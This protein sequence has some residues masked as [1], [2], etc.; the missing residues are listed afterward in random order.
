MPGYSGEARALSSAF[1]G[2]GVS[3]VDW[4]GQA[5]KWVM[6]GKVPP[7]A[8]LDGHCPEGR[9]GA[10]LAAPLTLVPTP[11]SQKQELGGVRGRAVGWEV[12]IQQVER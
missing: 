9:V 7:Q 1:V 6:M 12:L 5:R 11:F 4:P 10:G 3:Q 8:R 2:R